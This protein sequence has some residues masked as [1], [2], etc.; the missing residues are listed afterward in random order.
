M[1]LGTACVALIHGIAF[2]FNHVRLK[3][4]VESSLFGP[5]WRLNAKTS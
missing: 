3:Y 1:K 4:V 5:H 2:D